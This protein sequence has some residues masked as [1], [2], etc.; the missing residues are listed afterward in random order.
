MMDEEVREEKP[1]EP[2]RMFHS[3]SPKVYVEE[4]RVNS[5]LKFILLGL[6]VLLILGAL[7]Y[8]LIFSRDE[9]VKNDAVSPQDSSLEPQPSPS[10]EPTPIVEEIDRSGFTLRIL[11]GTK[12]SGLAASASATLK[13]L[14]YEVER[15][16][17]ATNSAF[18]KTVIRVKAG[19]E[20]LFEALIKDLMPMFEGEKGPG[21]RDSDAVDA[22]IILGR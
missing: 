14:G 13:G 18:L 16:G 22:E 6:V 19:S 8:L 7:G 20:S 2:H 11:N 4:R 3:S 1:A 21:L 9:E 5:K 15:T 10:P 17:N 12:T